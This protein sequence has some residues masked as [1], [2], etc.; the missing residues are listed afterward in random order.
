MHQGPSP[1]VGTPQEKEVQSA[2]GALLS[3]PAFNLSAD[4]GAAAPPP[5]PVQTQM[6]GAL[7]LK[8]DESAE[9]DGMSWGDSGRVGVGGGGAAAPNGGNN[10]VQR[11]AFPGAIQAKTEDAAVHTLP[12]GQ[13]GIVMDVVKSKAVDFAW[14][15]W[16]QLKQQYSLKTHLA[17]LLE[18]AALYLIDAGV[19]VTGIGAYLSAMTP[20]LEILKVVKTII[21]T[22]P[23]PIRVF[24]GWAIGAGLKK[25]SDKYMWGAIKEKHLNFLLIEGG[26]AAATIGQLIDFLYDLGHNPVQTIYKGI[27]AAVRYFTGNDEIDSMTDYLS[28]LEDKAKDATGASGGRNFGGGENEQ[29]GGEK[30]KLS[31]REQAQQDNMFNAD[32]GFFWV[33]MGQPKLDRWQDEQN[34]EEERGGLVVDGGLGLKVFGQAMGT[35]DIEIKIPYSTD[36]EM[37]F[38]D[39]MILSEPISLGN[40][41]R[42]GPVSM[43]LLKL[44]S[45]VG[46]DEMQLQ[47]LD[48]VFGND[49]FIAK[50]LGMSYSAGNKMLG[51]HGDTILNM[52]GYSIFGRF[53]L[54]IG[55]DGEF[56]GGWVDVKLPE[57]IDIIKDK[58]S[59]DNLNFIGQWGEE[60]L[61]LLELAGDIH[62]NFSD[63]LDF[64]AT[65]T[66]IRWQNGEF[67][68]L[69]QRLSVLVPLGANSFV[70]FS[71]DQGTVS[72]DGFTA[73]KITLK[74]MYGDEE[75]QEGNEQRLKEGRGDAPNVSQAD[76]TSIIPGFNLDW[77]QA[78]GLETL[79]VSA[80]A[81]GVSLN[82]DGL[83]IDGDL[84]KKL[85]RFAATVLGVKAKFDGDKNEGSL[86]GKW[87]YQVPNL[88][89]LGFDF[90]IVPGINAG[91]GVNANLEVG[92]ELDGSLR[93]MAHK[94]DGNVTP[95]ELGGYAGLFGN[96]NVQAHFDVSAG[97]PLLVSIHAGLFAE[98]GAELAADAAIH[99]TINWD[100][101]AHRV[102]L[103]KK[104]KELPSA[105]FDMHADLTAKL[106]AH[107]KAKAFHIFEVTLWEYE[108]VRWEM[109]LW[110]AKGRLQAKEDGGYEFKFEQAAFDGGR[111][112]RKPEID[113]R[114]AS[115]EEVILERE[116]R[117]DKIKDKNL[118]WRLA[119]DVSDPTSTMDEA[120]K[121]IMLEKLRRL[122]K[123]GKG[124]ETFLGSA[125]EFMSPRVDEGSSGFSLLMGKEEWV[126]YSTVKNWYG[127]TK[128]RGKDDRRVDNLLEK[129]HGEN[130]ATRKKEI[131]INLIDNVIPAYLHEGHARDEMITKL[132]K[133]AKRELERLRARDRNDADS[134]GGNGGW[135]AAPEGRNGGDNG[136][137][138]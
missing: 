59:L 57:E 19:R 8:A 108:F 111:P 50:E 60:G 70:E 131:L 21:E 77:I 82:G 5:A 110:R 71:M 100:E 126:K 39:L 1:V 116:R 85:H 129:Y 127:G 79:V 93:K 2:Q 56:K 135:S 94:K 118:M 84:E 91:V 11:V 122:N 109:G 6:P 4:G 112:G 138:D 35:D 92:A 105:S 37:T 74:F 42:G 46:V 9:S 49:V 33:R 38:R 75:T 36:W 55:T 78:T 106:G 7:Q 98:A 137:M 81:N 117:G 107:I 66:A 14:S 103:S 89:S 128:G 65:R 30:D 15:Y 132:L 73:D 24:I 62:A 22:I 83:N 125:G 119:H 64:D 61:E 136:R 90:P 40:F 86:E 34:P 29:E 123:T 10:P 44:R 48:F 96:A 67:M 80:S 26:D 104:E 99:G 23:R 43:P 47:L 115:P 12:E 134:M 63:K 124:L 41:F 45:G 53:H 13:D 16:D 28:H 17:E 18:R 133:D 130:N 95:W 121:R 20:Y 31:G 88:P 58:L 68:G 51:F 97:H 120:T 3:P 54:D 69:V 113:F 52:F 27:W 114:V 87:N 76:L 102:S 72:K 101:E 32:L 25:F